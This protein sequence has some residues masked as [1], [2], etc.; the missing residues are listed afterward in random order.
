MKV[1]VY[2]TDLKE[3]ALCNVAFWY[4]C[5]RLS[6]THE[7]C[8]WGFE[9]QPLTTLMFT[10]HLKSHHLHVQHSIVQ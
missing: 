10:S 5:E 6:E 4:K 8:E 7:N 2:G 9:D 1:C 3:R